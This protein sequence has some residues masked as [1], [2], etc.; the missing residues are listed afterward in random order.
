MLF[1]F[2]NEMFNFCIDN[3]VRKVIINKG[4]FSIFSSI[5]KKVRVED[6]SLTTEISVL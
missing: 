4:L 6:N 1:S 3:G 2:I 5:R